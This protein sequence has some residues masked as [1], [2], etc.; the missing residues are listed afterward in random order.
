MNRVIF[1]VIAL[2]VIINTSFAEEENRFG[3]TQLDFFG[4]KKKIK[5]AVGDLI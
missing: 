1:L 5:E 3:F 4:L 2:V